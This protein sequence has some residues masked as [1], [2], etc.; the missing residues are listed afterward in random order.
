MTDNAAEFHAPEDDVFA[1]I[2]GHYDR[3]CNYFSLYIQRHW[4]HEFATQAAREAGDSLLDIASG[5]GDIPQRVLR[6]RQIRISVTDICEPMLNIARRKLGGRDG[7]TFRYLDACDM[8]DVADN[9]Y[10]II[11]MAFG[12]KII[13]RQAA[14]AE[15]F[16]CL[17]P[18]G[19]FLNIDASVIPLPWL[20]RLYLN[21]MDTCLPLMG[22][23]IANGDA[24]A[25]QY[26]LK[27]IHDFPGGQAFAAEL[28]AYGFDDTTFRP[29]TLGIVAIHRAV[30]PLL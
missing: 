11:T 24:S 18:G 21:Y 29:L 8:S 5:T 22:R 2:A 10:D 26:L 25:Y 19:V 30:K 28:H 6:R 23:I 9:S 3:Y 12:M 1:R 27:G 16:R 15:I 14:L 17:K 7:V 20:Q 13:D 4:K